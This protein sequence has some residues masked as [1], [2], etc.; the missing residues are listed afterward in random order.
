MCEARLRHGLDVAH[1]HT[2]RAQ[3]SRAIV[4]PHPVY[5]RSTSSNYRVFVRKSRTRQARS[6]SA[7]IKHKS[8][9]GGGPSPKHLSNAL[10][11]RAHSLICIASV[12]RPQK[13]KRQGRS[14]LPNSGWE[15]ESGARLET[16]RRD[17]SNETFR[18]IEILLCALLAASLMESW[19][20]S[21]G[22]ESRGRSAAPCGASAARVSLHGLLGEATAVAKTLEYIRN[23]WAAFNKGSL[24]KTTARGGNVWR[25]Q[26][27][28]PAVFSDVCGV[29]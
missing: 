7:A 19:G 22:G 28:I 27:V 1:T 20:S 6:E 14:S 17:Q 10:T 23:S 16:P 2:R 12:L 9:T 18:P 11:S 26:S 3:Y 24:M 4:L 29:S 5:S 15:P 8:G 21:G 25:R 13:L